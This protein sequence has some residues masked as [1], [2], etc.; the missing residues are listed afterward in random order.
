MSQNFILCAFEPYVPH[1]FP[2]NDACI[3]LASACIRINPDHLNYAQKDAPPVNHL[4]LSFSV[5][6]LCI[7]LSKYGQISSG[8]SRRSLI[9]LFIKK[10]RAN[11]PVKI[12]HGNWKTSQQR[13]V[14][15]SLYPF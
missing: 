12:C 5:Y 9:S 15:E 10:P 2:T 3:P 13:D 6:I 1:L 7:M 8:Q 11:I 14:T 4:T